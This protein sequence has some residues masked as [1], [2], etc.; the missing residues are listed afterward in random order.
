MKP[1]VLICPLDWGLGHAARDI[2]IIEQLLKYDFKVIIGADKS[3]LLLLREHFPTLEVVKIKS[4]TIKYSKNSNLVLPL[5]LQSPKIIGGIIQEHSYLNKLIKKHNLD[6][7]ISDNRYGLW[8]KKIYNIFISHQLWIRSNN[9]SK[10]LERIINKIN[11]WF[12][13]K[14]QECWIPDIKGANNISGELS[15][16]RKNLKNFK[17]IGLISRFKKEDSLTEK[18]LKLQNNFNILVILSGPEPQRSLLEK[19]LV[20]QISKS[21]YKTLIIGGL[22]DK[23]HKGSYSNIT[24]VNHLKTPLLKEYLLKTPYVICRS[25]YSSIM[26]LVSLKKNAILIPTPGQTEQEYLAIRMRE[27]GWFYTVNQIEFNLDTAILQ[28]KNYSPNDI[29]IDYN[30]LEIVISK[31]RNDFEAIAS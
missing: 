1:K 19:L 4:P 8:N 26:D 6:I 21:N 14:Y 29:S 24:Y 10:V 7:I 11:H 28:L 15:N 25:G 9:N 12:I 30:Y 18:N 17:H 3:P 27:K 2:E 23:A 5:L 16:S 20:K 22:S 13:K 31:L